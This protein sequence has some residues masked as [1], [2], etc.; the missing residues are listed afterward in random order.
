[1]AAEADLFRQAGWE[2]E[3]AWEILE[4]GC[5]VPPSFEGFRH[6]LL[7]ERERSGDA[8]TAQEMAKRVVQTYRPIR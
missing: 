4:S 6:V 1:M 5:Q 2:Y 8:V 3:R 7:E